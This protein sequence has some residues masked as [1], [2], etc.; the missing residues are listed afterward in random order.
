VEAANWTYSAGREIHNAGMTEY[1]HVR[2]C[3]WRLPLGVHIDD[4]LS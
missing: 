1:S 3:V 4:A 2:L